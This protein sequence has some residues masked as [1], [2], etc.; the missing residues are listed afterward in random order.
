MQMIPITEAHYF[1]LVAA[2]AALCGALVGR[3]IAEETYNRRSAVFFAGY[4]GA[5][6]GLAAGP[7]FAVVLSLLTGSWSGENGLAVLSAAIES[8]GLAL[9]WGTIGGAVGGMIAGLLIAML[10]RIR[11]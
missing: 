4:T 9:M 6:A 11:A 1:L 8:T 5:G 7:P 2:F 3:I 10:G